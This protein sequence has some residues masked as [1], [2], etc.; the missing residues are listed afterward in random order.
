MASGQRLHRPTAPPSTPHTPT[1]R[2][3]S[4]PCLPFFPPPLLRPVGESARAFCAF[5]FLFDPSPTRSVSSRARHIAGGDGQTGMTSTVADL[6]R[7]V[8][9]VDAA[10]NPKANHVITLTA[11]GAVN[12]IGNGRV[13][14]PALAADRT[15]KNPWM[16]VS[17]HSLLPRFEDELSS[18]LF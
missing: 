16:P 17:E 10:G 7:Q 1:P 6:P 14:G 9:L 2:P 15:G 13:R 12:E 11:T 3:P 4:S 18:I 5:S 8:T